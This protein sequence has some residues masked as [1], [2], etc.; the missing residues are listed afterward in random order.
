MKQIIRIIAFTITLAMTPL[1]AGAG[2]SHTAGGG[3]Y[4]A[5]VNKAAAKQKAQKVVN[6]FIK[7]NI[8]DKSWSLAKL[9]SVEKKVIKGNEEWVVIFINN[10][11]P[12]KNKQK[13]YVFLTPS[14]KYIAANYTGN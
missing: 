13:L 3:H 8:I 9:S 2:H 7:K 5:P 12:D 10:K 14:G 6:S 1:F 4:H 11:L